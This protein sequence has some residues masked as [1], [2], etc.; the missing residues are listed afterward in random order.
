MLLLAS[1][2]LAMWWLNNSELNG[3]WQDV[4]YTAS[5]LAKHALKHDSTT[6]L[7][8]TDGLVAFKLIATAVK[9]SST[10]RAP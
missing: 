9:Y 2:V 1:L 7:G 5:Y 6:D 3:S 4:A 8:A 10:L